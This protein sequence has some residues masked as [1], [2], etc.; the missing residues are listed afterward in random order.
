MQD[1]F[2]KYRMQ[3]KGTKSRRGASPSCDLGEYINED[4]LDRAG[5]NFFNS[6]VS[7]TLTGLALLGTFLG[8]SM[9]WAHLAATTFFPSPTMWVP[10][11][12]V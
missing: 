9:V 1:A 12:L 11:F 4:L 10:C 8:R 5:M 7:G 6:G 3:A 2:N